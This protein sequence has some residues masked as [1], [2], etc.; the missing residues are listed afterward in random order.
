M[1]VSYSLH[2][3][4]NYK[5]ALHFAA[6]WGCSKTLNILL[7][8]P[9]VKLNLRDEDGKTPLF[10]VLDLVLNS[11]ISVAVAGTGDKIVKY[12]CFA[13]EICS[14]KSVE[15]LIEEGANASIASRDS[16]NAFEYAL[17]ELGDNKVDM[18]KYLYDK[19]G[20]RAE[21]KEKGKMSFI[22]VLT[23]AKKGVPISKTMKELL[24]T[25]NVN[26]TEGNG[27]T[28]LILATRVKRLDAVKCLVE[29]YADPMHLDLAQTR[30]IGYAERNSEIYNVLKEAMNNANDRTL[31][32]KVFLEKRVTD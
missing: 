20:M 13:V 14:K 19:G 5:T 18:I 2:C 26:A 25:E 8:V 9:G 16:R 1:H 32:M 10:K 11:L 30:A 6:S 29:H 4:I 28:A 15:I 12:R 22:H 21:R 3:K 27:R 24:N 7:K 31:G 17:Q 23:L